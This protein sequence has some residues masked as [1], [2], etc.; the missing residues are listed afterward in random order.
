MEEDK[1][2]RAKGMSVVSVSVDVWTKSEPYLGLMQTT[3]VRRIDAVCVQ[4][5]R[6]AHDRA[7]C[8]D[9]Y[10]IIH[11]AVRSSPSGSK[12][13]GRVPVLCTREYATKTVE[14]Y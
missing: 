6:V 10:R 9:E 14:A 11:I 1:R 3:K 12:P 7:V 2:T 4:T 5:T 8:L 13:A